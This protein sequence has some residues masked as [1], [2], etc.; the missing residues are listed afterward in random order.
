MRTN[1]C[2]Y[3]NLLI[4]SELAIYSKDKEITTMIII[5]IIIIRSTIM[6]TKKEKKENQSQ[7]VT[8]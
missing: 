7:I 1:I 2:I 6:S 4:T 8:L 3:F 5:I